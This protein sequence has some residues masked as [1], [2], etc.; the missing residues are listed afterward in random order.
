VWGFGDADMINLFTETGQ[1]LEHVRARDK[2]ALGPEIQHDAVRFGAG[3]AI[4]S[5]SFH[6]YQREDSAWAN[7]R[8]NTPQN[9]TINR[10]FSLLRAAFNLAEEKSGC[11]TCLISLMMPE[12]NGR[13]GSSATALR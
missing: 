11:A 5:S 4:P 9:V 12:D 1:H 2:G 6:R 8:T 10:V 3:F 7:E 13:D